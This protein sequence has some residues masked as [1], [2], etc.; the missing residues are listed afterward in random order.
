MAKA[1]ASSVNVSRTVECIG[2][3]D[4]VNSIKSNGGGWKATILLNDPEV[5]ADL[6]HGLKKVCMFNIGISEEKGNADGDAGQLALGWLI[7]LFVVVFVVTGHRQP[8]SGRASAASMAAR[9]TVSRIGE[10]TARSASP[11]KVR[12]GAPTKETI[13]C[14]IARLMMP[15]ARL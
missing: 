5:I 13:S 8:P 9:Q 11:P 4:S 7:F 2:T 1:K 14:G 3:I 15:S 12:A 10:T 6:S